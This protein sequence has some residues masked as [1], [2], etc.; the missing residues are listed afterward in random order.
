MADP[1]HRTS[2][3]LDYGYKQLPYE[4]FLGGGLITA[5]SVPIITAVGLP[6]FTVASI[7]VTALCGWLG[8][9]RSAES[10]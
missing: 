8:M 2:A 3:A 4:P 5:L 6:V 1:G 9:R 10:T 7:V